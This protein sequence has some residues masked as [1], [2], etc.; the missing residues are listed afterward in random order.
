MSTEGFHDAM[1]LPFRVGD[2]VAR[3][4]GRYPR[5]GYRV[6]VERL[7]ETRIIVRIQKPEPEQWFFGTIEFAGDWVIEARSN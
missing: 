5:N 7:E 4:D 2:R 6:L 3:A 1:G